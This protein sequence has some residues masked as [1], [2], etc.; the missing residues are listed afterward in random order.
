MADREAWEAGSR[1]AVVRAAQFSIDQIGDLYLK[2]FSV[3]SRPLDE[4]SDSNAFFFFF[5][6]RR[7][8]T[9]LVSDWSA[10]VC[11]SDLVDG[12]MPQTREHVLL[13]SQVNVRY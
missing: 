10:D 4:T 9:R 7:L 12:P 8:H 3:F 13:A 11:S 5:S 6:S 2:G 1:A